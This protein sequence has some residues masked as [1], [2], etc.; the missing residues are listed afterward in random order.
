MGT[1]FDA[2]EFIDDDLDPA[3]KKGVAVGVGTAVGGSN[4]GGPTTDPAPSREDVDAKVGEMQHK[5]AELKRAQQELERERASLEE[6]RRRQTEFTTGREEMIQHLTRG[7]GLLGETEFNARREVELMA[8]T[9]TALREALAKI[10]SI[11]EETWTKENLQVELTRASTTIENA[12]MEWNSARL[13]F[14]QLAGE[15][16]LAAPGP[17]TAGSPEWRELLE[18]RSYAEICKLGLALTWPVALAGLGIVLVL[19]LR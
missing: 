15:A 10:E 9:L 7:V 18:Q 6:L 1:E 13:K 17:V 12:R 16:P 4:A 11:H 8:K 19:L 5:L 14:P 2:S 3:P